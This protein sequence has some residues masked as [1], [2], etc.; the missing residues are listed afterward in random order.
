[1]LRY[2]SLPVRLWRRPWSTNP[3]MRGSDRLESAVWL[4]AVLVMSAVI[5]LAGA[6]GTAEYTSAAE[7]IRAENATKSAVTAVVLAEPR[8]I[9]DAEAEQAV[10][11]RFEAPVRWVHE[12]REHTAAVEVSAAAKPGDRLPIWIGGDAALTTP[13]QPSA[14]AVFSA[15]AVAV[16]L[17]I[18]V[19]IGAMAL[20]WFAGALLNVRR[21]RRWDRE[22]RLIA[23]PMGKEYR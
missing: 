2:P 16:G 12:G 23:G 11:A 19:W 17:L 10:I 15:A 8:R 1:M 20:A 3:L 7:R 18:E 9:T 4:V 14:A 22:W 5:P 13:P 6:A 21:R